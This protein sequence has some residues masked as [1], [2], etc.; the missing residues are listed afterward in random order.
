MRGGPETVLGRGDGTGED[1]E[2]G[3]NIAVLKSRRKFQRVWISGSEKQSGRRQGCREYE[4][5]KNE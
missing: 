1:P 2:E 4:L 5:S 3:K